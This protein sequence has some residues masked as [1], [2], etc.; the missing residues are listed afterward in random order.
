MPA[1][2]T[3]FSSESQKLEV[4]AYRGTRERLTTVNLKQALYKILSISGVFPDLGDLPEKNR[5]VTRKD[6]VDSEYFLTW[7]RVIKRTLN[8]LSQILTRLSNTC[9]GGGGLPPPKNPPERRG[10]GG[11]RP[12]KP[13]G[14][15]ALRRRSRAAR[16]R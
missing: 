15:A 1:P 16:P 6:C 8:F 3:G 14:E 5:N 10:E 13:P 12:P 9:A 11:Y 2:G 4:A 7:L